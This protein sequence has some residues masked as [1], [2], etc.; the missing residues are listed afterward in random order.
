M[1]VG[2]MEFVVEEGKRVNEECSTLIHFLCFSEFDLS[3]LD[4]SVL[5]SKKIV[6]FMRI[7]AF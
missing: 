7:K 2:A 1:C 3:P 6:A 4:I 5:K